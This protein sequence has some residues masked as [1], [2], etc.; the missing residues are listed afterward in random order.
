[1]RLFFFEEEEEELCCVISEAKISRKAFLREL[2]KVYKTILLLSEKLIDFKETWNHKIGDRYEEV[3]T[4]HWTPVKL[5]CSVFI[6]KT[7]REYKTSL[8]SLWSLWT[9]N[10]SYDLFVGSRNSP[11]HPESFIRLQT[12]TNQ[13]GGLL[14]FLESNNTVEQSLRPPRPNQLSPGAHGPCTLLLTYLNIVVSIS[15]TCNFS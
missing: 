7:K 11:I 15:Q 14:F 12:S 10:N 6:S 1:M 13:R 2:L 5:S 8:L 3:L 9:Q 4:D